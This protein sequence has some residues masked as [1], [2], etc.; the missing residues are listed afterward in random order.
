[1]SVMEVTFS[2]REKEEIT[3]LTR[4]DSAALVGIPTSGNIGQKWRT[5]L[6]CG[7]S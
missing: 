3:P 5:Q 6:R 1:M 2:F 7:F 4:A